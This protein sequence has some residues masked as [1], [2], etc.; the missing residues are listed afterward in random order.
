MTNPT[1]QRLLFVWVTSEDLKAFYND[2]QLGPVIS[3]LKAVNFDKVVLLSMYELPAYYTF[4]LTEQVPEIQLYLRICNY[5]H[6]REDNVLDWVELL[7]RGFVHKRSQL[8]FYL[9][10]SNLPFSNM[11][12]HLHKFRYPN[13]QLMQI[14][15]E[16]GFELLKLNPYTFK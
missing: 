11:W 15:S 2:K 1:Y 10:S 4:W 3:L 13:A 7:V 5:R 12:L 16:G 8:V 9:D 14:S 6:Y